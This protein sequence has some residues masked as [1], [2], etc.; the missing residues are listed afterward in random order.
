MENSKGSCSGV[1][2]YLIKWIDLFTTTKCNLSCDYCFH[3]NRS[4]G[5]TKFEDVISYIENIDS[6]LA[7]NMVINF[8]GGE[9]LLNKDLIIKVVNHYK[10]RKYK[11]GVCTNGTIFD[12]D[13][14]KF[15][16]DHNIKVQVSIDG[17]EETHNKARSKHKIIAE[18]IKKMI[19]LGVNVNARM[20][21]SPETVDKLSQNISYVHSLGINRIM[22]Q[23]VEEANW[24]EKSVLEFK[25]QTKKIIN[26]VQ[27][28]PNVK[29]TY[30]SRILKDCQSSHGLLC[31]AGKE[32][33]ALLPNGD[34]YPCHRF[35]SREKFCLGNAM[36]RFSRGLFLD[37][38]RDGIRACK[39][40]KAKN[41]CHTCIAAN[42]E[43]NGSM[44]E[45][46]EGFCNIIKAEHEIGGNMKS[47]KEISNEERLKN[48]E[49]IVSKLS[50]VVIDI[51]KS[52]DTQRE[53][54]K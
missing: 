4:L 7:P 40:C 26:F 20:T 38:T 41:I 19:S 8:F 44:M 30:I 51:S 18:N 33:I 29:L 23:G 2:N 54:K 46:I 45:P 49:E 16:I 35:A 47:N 34:I 32:M 15:F 25:D 13:L 36:N 9:P 11:Y 39:N 48:I 27:K 37:I 6:Y 3:S 21:Y 5:D 12:V 50:L 31:K 53:K 14:F 28:N 10:D 17:D 52:L 1:N 43:V 22:H 42:H 24:D